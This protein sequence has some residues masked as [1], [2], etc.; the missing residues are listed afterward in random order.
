MDS[1]IPQDQVVVGV[2]VAPPPPCPYQAVL[3]GRECGCVVLGDHTVHRFRS[4]SGVR[5]EFELVD[6]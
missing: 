1:A 6:P 5:H 4:R 2:W 3:E